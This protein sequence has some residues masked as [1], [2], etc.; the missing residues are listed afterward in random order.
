MGIGTSLVGVILI[1]DSIEIRDPDGNVA[2]FA[3]NALTD[4]AVGVVVAV[5]VAGFLLGAISTKGGLSRTAAG[6]AL[7]LQTESFRRFLAQSEGRHVEEAHRLG[8][9]ANIRHGQSCSERPL[10]GRRPPTLLTIWRSQAKLISPSPLSPTSPFSRQPRFLRRRATQAV[11][12]AVAEVA[13][14]VE[15]A[16]IPRLVATIDVR[17]FIYGIWCRHPS[18]RN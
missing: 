8:V 3:P 18:Q 13:A 5:A 6:S 11:A 15:E 7:Y 12:A 14:V 17:S 9:C 1:L 4:S 2:D 16:A 10:R